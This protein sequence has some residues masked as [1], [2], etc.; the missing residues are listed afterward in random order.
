MLQKRKDICFILFYPF[1]AKKNFSNNTNQLR[2]YRRGI[3]S[4][5]GLSGLS[6]DL[7][8]IGGDDE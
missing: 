5:P 1:D 6:L 4:G 7:H 2:E 8:Q 3:I